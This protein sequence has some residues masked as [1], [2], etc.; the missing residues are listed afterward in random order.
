MFSREKN[1][2]KPKENNTNQSFNNEAFFECIDNKSTSKIIEYLEE[3]GIDIWKIKEDNNF[4]PIHKSVILNDYDITKLLI[5]EIKKILGSEKLLSKYINEKANEDMTA[6]HYAALKGN[7]KIL[8]LLLDNGA[9]IECRTTRGKNIMHLAAEG[10]QPSMI[11]YLSENKGQDINSIDELGSTSLHWACYSGAKDAALFLLSLNVDINMQDRDGYTPLHLAALYGHSEVVKLLLHK[12][13]D[14]T[15]PNK[16]RELPIDLAEKKNYQNI[17]NILSDDDFDPLCTLSSPIYYIKPEN[18]YKK[19]IF[20]MILVPEIIIFFFILPFLLGN[21]H[22]WINFICFIIEIF[23]YVILLYKDPGY[24]LNKPLISDAKNDHKENP[25]S[26]LVNQDID[27]RDYCPFCYIL[28][29][30]NQNRKKIKHCYICNKCVEDFNHHCFWI[31]K[32]IGKGNKFSYICFIVN[33]LIFS[34]HILFMCFE[35]LYDDVTFKYKNKNFPPVIN[36]FNTSKEIRTLGAIIIS[37]F[38]II[39]SFPLSFLLLIEICKSLGYF[40][41]KEKYDNNDN[42]DN[43]IKI[44]DINDNKIINDEQNNKIIKDE[45]KDSLL[46]N[47]NNNDIGDINVFNEED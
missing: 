8:N 14:K 41:F 4:T 38:C 7:I 24:Y 42:K 47:I 18:V 17:K 44:E 9:S 10:N 37:I 30:N 29:R 2:P 46:N 1:L 15:I 23:S 5:N 33:S 31:N 27:I 39:L 12:N 20:I 19:Y 25:L 45:E 32:C 3:P 22:N 28:Y 16:K 26:L 36:Y 11:L 35:L 13:A 34:F 21:V 6:L 40:N 43:I